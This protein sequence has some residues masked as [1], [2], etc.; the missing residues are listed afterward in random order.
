MQASLVQFLSMHMYLPADRAEDPQD[1]AHAQRSWWARRGRHWQA[2]I[3]IIQLAIICFITFYLAYSSGSL[4][5]S[6]LGLTDVNGAGGASMK[7]SQVLLTTQPHPHLL[8]GSNHLDAEQCPGLRMEKYWG[9]PP[10]DED[11]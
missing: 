5:E 3:I 4:F 11:T 9:R 1:K 2:P 6:R 8:Y 10:S 7:G